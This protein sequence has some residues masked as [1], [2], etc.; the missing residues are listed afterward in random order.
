MTSNQIF[1]LCI[2]GGVIL[3]GIIIV[4]ACGASNDKRI[5]WLKRAEHIVK[6]KMVDKHET[7][8][9]TTK[10][11]TGSAIA[12]GV[13]GSAVAGPIKRFFV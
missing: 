12:R 3:I 10:A 5:D 2:V 1:S 8:T 11:S 13:V 9:S 7:S 6:T 4:A